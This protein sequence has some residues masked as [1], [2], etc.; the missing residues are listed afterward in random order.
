[1][2]RIWIAIAAGAIVA[3]V[4]VLGLRLRLDRSVSSEPTVSVTAPERVRLDSGAEV[5]IGLG[6]EADPRTLEVEV[7]REDRSSEVR[8]GRG[9]AILSLRDL[10]RGANEVRLRVRDRGGELHER[11]VGVEGLPRRATSLDAEMRRVVQGIAR[12]RESQRRRAHPPRELV[13]V[14]ERGANLVGNL[15]RATTRE[16]RAE[17]ERELIRDAAR[18]VREHA[19]QAID[20]Y[21]VASRERS[22][23]GSERASARLEGLQA[24]VARAAADAEEVLRAAAEAEEAAELR[25]L[26]ARLEALT[27]SP[28]RPPVV[29]PR[30]IPFPA[31]PPEEHPL[32]RHVHEAAKLGPDGEVRPAGGEVMALLREPIPPELR[33]EGGP[34]LWMGESVAR[35]QGS[36]PDLEPATGVRFGG[37]GDPITAKATELGN[38]PVA[39]YEFV[40]NE[41]E[42]ELYGALSRGAAATLLAGAGNNPDQVALL[43]ALLRA[44]GFPAR[45]VVGDIAAPR[46]AVHRWLQ[47]PE[48]HG[49]F[50][51]F[52]GVQDLLSF[53]APRPAVDGEDYVIFEHWWV[54]ALVPYGPDQG[55]DLDGPL[56]WV[57]LDPS[58]KQHETNFNPEVEL[59]RAG[60]D[61]AQH[62]VI[63]FGFQGGPG[64]LG[65]VTNR[66]PSE[67]YLEQKRDRLRQIAPGKTLRDV[68][69]RGP[70]VRKKLGVLPASL[71][72]RP[73][74]YHLEFADVDALPDAPL[75]P[76]GDIDRKDLLRPRIFVTLAD[77]ATPSA[78]AVR[79]ALV[80]ADIA[81]QRI[82]VGW[83]PA[84]G[85][86]PASCQGDLTLC[87]DPAAVLLRAVLYVDGTPV[88]PVPGL[89]PADLP[90]FTLDDPISVVIGSTTIPEQS[91][92][93]VGG[94]VACSNGTVPRE[95]LSACYGTR[96]TRLA[97]GDRWVLATDFGH[98]S[99]S[100]VDRHVRQLVEDY[101]ALLAGRQLANCDPA[102][103]E[104][105]VTPPALTEA[106][107]EALIGG[108]LQVGALR[109][110][111][112]VTEGNRI[113]LD[114]E[115]SHS[116][117]AGRGQTQAQLEV[118]YLDNTPVAVVPDS[119]VIDIPYVGA[120]FDIERVVNPQAMANHERILHRMYGLDRSAKEH[121]LWEE[122]VQTE[123]IS[124]VK[125]L[126][127]ANDPDRGGNL[128]VLKMTDSVPPGVDVAAGVPGLLAQGYTVYAPDRFIDLNGWQ[129]SLYY[130]ELFTDQT[131]SV[132]NAIA[133]DFSGSANGGWTFSLPPID[134]AD[135]VEGIWFIGA[136]PERSRV[137]DP[138]NII[139]GNLDF[140]ETDLVIPAPGQQPL[141]LTR[142]Y[143]S[144]LHETG[145]FGFGWTHSYRLLLEAVD[146]NANG[147]PAEPEDSD[148]TVS[149]VAF[150]DGRG[151][152]R[153]FPIVSGS[154]G[155][156]AAFTGAAAE[157]AVLVRESPGLVL[158]TRNG[159]RFEFPAFPQGAAVGQR[160]RAQAIVDPNG[161]TTEILYLG[162][163]VWKV[164]DPLDRELRFDD[165]DGNGKVDR[166][167][168][169]TGRTWHYFYDGDDLREVRNPVDAAANRPT[170][171]YEYYSGQ[172][173]PAND[174]NLRRRE[175]ALGEG[176]TYFYYLNDKVYKTIDDEGAETRFVYDAF[177]QE[178]RQ[179]DALGREALF[180]YDR[181]GQLVRIVR[182]DGSVQDFEYDDDRNLT[183]EIDALGGET[184][185]TYD[186]FGSVKTE[187]TPAGSFTSFV[188]WYEENPGSAPGS[189][190]HNRVV[191]RTDPNGNVFRFNYDVKGNVV[192]ESVRMDLEGTGVLTEV[193]LRSHT[194]D[195]RGNRRKTIENIDPATPQI[196]E[197]T[198]RVV[199]VEYDGDKLRPIERR[200]AEGGV[201]R[202]VWDVDLEEPDRGLL[203]RVEVPRVA[204]HPDG[205][206]QE[207]TLVE[208]REYD[209]LGR[210]TLV[211]GPLGTERETV[212]DL[213]GRMEKQIVRAEEATGAVGV[214]EVVFGRDS[215]GRIVT[216]TDPAGNVTVLGYDLVGNLTKVVD[217]TGRATRFR[218]DA[219][220]RQVARV[221]PGGAMTRFERDALGRLVEQVD[222]TDRRVRLEYDADG[223]Q[224]AQIQCAPV[225][226]CD[227]AQS[228][229][230]QFARDPN[231][232]RVG[233]RSPRLLAG[234][235]PANADGFSTTFVYDELGRLVAVR[236]AEDEEQRFTLNLLG[237][238]TAITDR[239]QNDL[240][241]EFD[242]VGRLERRIHPGGREERFAY[243]SVGN[244]IA[245]WDGQDRVTTMHYDLVD[246]EARVRFA[247]GR[248]LVFGFDGFGNLVLARSP[249][250]TYTT[251]YDA[252]GRPRRRTDSRF[253]S[254]LRF[255]W[256][257]EGRL[258]SQTDL[259]GG[260]TQRRYGPAGRLLTVRRAGGARVERHYDRAGRLVA[261]QAMRFAY[262]AFGRLAR[263]EALGS[264][265]AYT[266]DPNGNV[267]TVERNEGAVGPGTEVYTY[268]AL[269]RLARVDYPDG[270][271]QHY[272]YDPAGNRIHE[273]DR[274]TERWHVYDA[275]N[276]RT[277]TTADAG[278]TQVQR[279]YAYDPAHGARASMT[280][281]ATG[282]TWHY[283]WD[284][285]GQ[286]VG[287]ED[288]AAQTWTYAYDA[289]GQRISQE[290]PEKVR[291]YVWAGGNRVAEYG[292]A[293]GS[294]GLHTRYVYGAGLDDLVRIEQEGTPWV[295]HRDGLRSV[296]G[297][298]NGPLGV[299]TLTYEAWGSLLASVTV[300]QAPELDLGFAG[301]PR[302]SNGLVQ[303]RARYYDPASGS[304]L[305]PDPLGPAGGLNLYLYAAANPATLTDRRGL[306]P[307]I[308][309]SPV[310]VGAGLTGSPTDAQLIAGGGG[311]QPPF[312]VDSPGQSQ[313]DL[314]VQVASAGNVARDAGFFSSQSG[315]EDV[316]FRA[317]VFDG[318]PVIIPIPGGD[319]ETLDAIAQGESLGTLAGSG[320]VVCAAG[321]CQAAGT[322]AA[323]GAGALARRGA[324]DFLRGAAQGLGEGF[325]T[326]AA[327]AGQKDPLA[328]LPAPFGTPARQAGQKTGRL[329]GR[330]IGTGVRKADDIAEFL[331]GVGV[332][333]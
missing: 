312:Q 157:H 156:D 82:S 251:E 44:A 217:R 32:Q 236:D 163:R 195:F 17:G 205:L 317:T 120:P 168:D 140:S 173:A 307:E 85:P 196:D 162:V 250:V 202:L 150:L 20:Y 139:S 192:L 186:A 215:Q 232:N 116:L 164:R 198:D 267:E 88:T 169:W 60:E 204:H 10:D 199:T 87:D 19:D 42:F 304:F 299:H 91:S 295:I 331:R 39:I 244:P 273:N 104:C 65:T 136:D 94:G 101:D 106:Q 74:A 90:V 64:L 158:K 54:K 182:P 27:D 230:T 83:E 123:A 34:R 314:G 300:G 239:R 130:A 326:G 316:A 95:H 208:E 219:R 22:A 135:Q 80:Q 288:P 1:M 177:R 154:L 121:Q 263:V 51:N 160:V 146:D 112:R 107:R 76:G 329:I 113:F 41:I 278:G 264:L 210:L 325:V 319:Q 271:H 66:T 269:D 102:T 332:P 286:L 131:R 183:R 78:V 153:R 176:M 46:P 165:T 38:D 152:R 241:Q 5:R 243:D 43:V 213:A 315:Q 309:L 201:A 49:G 110:S 155:V 144:Q 33:A 191:Q 216:E 305:S 4:L 151:S 293:D 11:R 311:Q 274:G 75:F 73:V 228:L 100:A 234:E 223:F 141:E 14:I 212:Y 188:Y 294:G 287:V 310:D 272:G 143:N 138:V 174:H 253:G 207:S 245:A 115:R 180:Q 194:Y 225:G 209:L 333:F 25:A 258:L 247:D 313:S 178:T 134:V 26:R 47:I 237:N 303:M 203:R 298:A 324:V 266:Y 226:A 282:A 297:V 28:P 3:A 93:L 181:K 321:A 227:P 50:L 129:G 185:R 36:N 290:A 220:D 119:L 184:I 320:A 270:T 21:T 77:A 275:A 18:A 214:R 222:P 133:K 147:I 124:T 99:D 145:A 12:I 69:I 211:R 252:L 29:A 233:I 231:G 284:A 103:H 221:D 149:A 30:P 31:R 55:R 240:V 224:T 246:R 67:I 276:R 128:T 268:D 68:S 175:N 89:D 279:T 23:S 330:G 8:F 249:A 218:Y 58:F 254:A 61:P 285:A 261:E 327:G 70:I 126:Q 56:R 111:E 256:D 45:F 6:G 48:V 322:A 248:D 16:L 96:L 328:R 148:G 242:R 72:Y 79:R 281:A 137:G 59:P 166:V 15:E 277:A 206:Q 86:L 167:V 108:L 255:T 127:I 63:D 53:Y 142:T 200:D 323:A 189:P 24:T 187:R 193:Q 301:R 13:E 292:G 2:R 97:A 40:R 62:E 57:F 289:L 229:E 171:T 259:E 238:A 265:R 159:T 98:G 291:A 235:I 118:K 280:E 105:A 197:G 84:N 132:I 172:F 306:A 125:G 161:N 308:V 179:I 262:D 260:V 114:L 35:A 283:T 122:L 302:D 170:S 257:A 81:S 117:G 318:V 52:N 92:V 37:P 296:I 71:P 7:N 190:R 9:G 109:Y